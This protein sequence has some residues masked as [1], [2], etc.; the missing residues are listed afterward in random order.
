MIRDQRVLLIVG[1]DYFDGSDFQKWSE[2]VQRATMLD[3]LSINHSI[4]IHAGDVCFGS[5]NP[6]RVAF[7]AVN[8]RVLRSNDFLDGVHFPRVAELFVKAADNSF[9]LIQ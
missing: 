2:L 8:F 6:G 5:I 7:A 4:N 9:V 3:D 1:A